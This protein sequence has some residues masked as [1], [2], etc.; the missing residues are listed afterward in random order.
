LAAGIFIGLF[1]YKPQFGILLPVALIASHQ[2]RAIVSAAATIIL[3][4]GI[5]IA[6]FGV[7]AWEACPRQLLAQAGLSL[8]DPASN[9]SY[10]QTVY[11]LIHALHGGASLAWVAQGATTLCAAVIVWLAWRSRTSFSLKAAILSAAAFVVTPYAFAYDMASLVI[12][13]A[14]LARDQL[15]R[16][17]L[18]GDKTLWIVLFGV[19]LA[20]LVTL[21]DNV[22]GPTFGATPVGLFTAILLLAMILHRTIAVQPTAALNH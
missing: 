8:T 18:K 2:W 21:G 12:P 1:S 20:V 10:L 11:G 5:S 7:G 13:A 6:A 4:A 15:R 9:W 22:G 19:P 16:G 14:F 17:L 3:L